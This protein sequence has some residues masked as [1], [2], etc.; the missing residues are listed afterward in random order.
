MRATNGSSLRIGVTSLYPC[1]TRTGKFRPY[2]LVWITKQGGGFLNNGFHPEAGRFNAG[3]KMI[4]WT[5]VLGG[6][7]RAST[8]SVG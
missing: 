3:Q 2:D 6:L 4:F 7:A 5:V 8:I 1:D